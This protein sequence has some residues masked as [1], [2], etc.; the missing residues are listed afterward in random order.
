MKN[1]IQLIPRSPYNTGRPSHRRSLQPEKENI[2]H[3]KSKHDIFT[4]FYF[5]WSF[6][7]SWIPIR[8]PNPDPLRMRNNGHLG[9]LTSMLKYSKGFLDPQLYYFLVTLC[10]YNYLTITRGFLSHET[11][12]S[13]TCQTKP[14]HRSL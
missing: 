6:L 10:L 5:S 11:L 14:S 8:M 9:S 2:Q 7:P 13:S 3:L 1:S 4:F 12:A